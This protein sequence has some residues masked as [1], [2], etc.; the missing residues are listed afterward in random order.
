[1]LPASVYP[2]PIRSRFVPFDYGDFA[3][4]VD[5]KAWRAASSIQQI[6][7]LWLL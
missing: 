4:A 7:R 1:M 2:E 5:C 3:L 6:T